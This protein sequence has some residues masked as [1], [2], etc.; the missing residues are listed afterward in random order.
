MNIEIIAEVEFQVTLLLQTIYA[1]YIHQGIH[2]TIHFSF[3]IGML[4]YL[5]DAPIQ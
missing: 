2:E 5:S 3:H 4:Q 1:Y